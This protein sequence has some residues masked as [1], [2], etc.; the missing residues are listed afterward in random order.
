MHTKCH[1]DMVN[2]CNFVTHW[3]VTL[4][5]AVGYAC[6][7]WFLQG[8]L[9]LVTGWLRSWLRSLFVHRHLV[10]LHWLLRGGQTCCQ[11]CAKASKVT[12]DMPMR[13]HNNGM[14]ET[15]SCKWHGQ[16][17]LRDLFMQV[18]RWSI[19]LAHPSG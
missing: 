19:V 9:M 2:F 4:G 17:S 3:L 10:S 14:L 18:A 13:L 6:F 15:C 8:F 11:C 1:H 5:Y 12:V 16:C 7:C